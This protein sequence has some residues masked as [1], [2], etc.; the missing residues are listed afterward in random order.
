MDLF[1]AGGGILELIEWKHLFLSQITSESTFDANERRVFL[2]G[3]GFAKVFVR[4]NSLGTGR[5]L[6]ER[7]P[8]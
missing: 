6:K 5:I 1:L 4:S 2:E 8:K 3:Y 7:V